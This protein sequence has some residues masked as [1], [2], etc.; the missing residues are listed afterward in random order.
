MSN[1]TPGWN[2]IERRQETVSKIDQFKA[3][4]GS[5]CALVML[6]GFVVA[7]ISV[8]WTGKIL[9]SEGQYGT[10]FGVVLAWLL[11]ARDAE[12]QAKE[13]KETM[14]A[15]AEPAK[16]AVAK[17]EERATIAE[18]KAAAA[19]APTVV[20]ATPPPS[21]TVTVGPAPPGETP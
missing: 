21:T 18:A 16:I 20:V 19:P 17:A 11:K 4:T 10:T 8:L 7:Y 9:I 2:G 3:A 1:G 15:A 13:V 6:A 14:K 5:V 12:Q